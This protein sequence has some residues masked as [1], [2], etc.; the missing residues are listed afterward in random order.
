[1]VRLADAVKKSDMAKIKKKKKGSVRIGE[2]EKAAADKEA[3]PES[4]EVT[5]EYDEARARRV[6]D[7]IERE[8]AAIRHEKVTTVTTDTET[9]SAPTSISDE[10]E[11]IYGGL[12]G[13][14]EEVGKSV[15]KGKRFNIEEGTELIGVVVNNPNILDELYQLTY[16]SMRRK[17]NFLSARAVHVLINAI[18]MAKGFGYLKPKQIEL[19]TAALFHDIGMYKV[20]DNIIKKEGELTPSEMKVIKEHP[21][22]SYDELLKYG[23]KYHWL[24]E[25]VYQEHERLDGSGYPRGLKGEDIHEYASIIG[26][27]DLYDDL[28]HGRPQRDGLLPAHAVR[29]I[30]DGSKKLF[31]VAVIKNLL[32]QI[33]HYPVRSFVKLNDNSIGMVVRTN[34]LWSLKPTVRL[35]C[36]AKGEKTSEETTVDLAKSS[37]LYIEDAISEEDIPDLGQ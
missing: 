20:P 6:H 21:K 15:R 35:I 5:T 34:P 37:F 9:E 13:Y 3:P 31:P 19:G 30:L 11:D 12:I 26:V 24:A 17:E 23:D 2:A 1:M 18:L 36:D 8:M 22:A 33:S 10:A 4:E 25:V 29:E 32:Q 16:N 27:L 28:I 7:V 14:M